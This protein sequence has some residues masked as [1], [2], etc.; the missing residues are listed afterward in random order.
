MSSSISLRQSSSQHL[1]GLQSA[2]LV[3]YQFDTQIRHY[4][5]LTFHFLFIPKISLI[6][7]YKKPIHFKGIKLSNTRS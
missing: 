3:P 6:L 2:D 1:H 5:T 7:Q 4:L